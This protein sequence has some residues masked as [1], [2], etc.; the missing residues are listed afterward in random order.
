[1]NKRICICLLFLLYTTF[2]EAS[3]IPRDSVQVVANWKQGERYLYQVNRTV[4]EMDQ[5][6]LLNQYTTEAIYSFQVIHATAD[7]YTIRW[8]LEEIKLS[9]EAWNNPVV[10]SILSLFER[11]P[12]IYTTD[13]MGEFLE[14]QNWLEV[15]RRVPSIMENILNRNLQDRTSLIQSKELTYKVLS[16]LFENRE[17][18]ES[19]LLKEIIMLHGFHGYV[20]PL[21]EETPYEDYI[22]TPYGKPIRAN[23]FMRFHDFNRRSGFVEA[24]VQYT[25]DERAF[26]KMIQGLTSKEGAQYANMKMENT[27]QERYL[28]DTYSGRVHQMV[29]SQNSVSVIE[30][31]ERVKYEKMELT[32]IE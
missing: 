19:S 16:Q 18:A 20:Y 1:M 28:I 6:R 32:L 17:Q 12:I 27:K 23:G 8:M 4:R 31:K 11:V 14:W 30:G 26:R 9:K 5:D 21:E 29:F 22:K 24:D 15:K 2:V 25:L 13:N 7:L 3:I 10:A